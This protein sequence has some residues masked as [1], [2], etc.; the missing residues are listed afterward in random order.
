MKKA[1]S[2]YLW[3]TLK[4]LQKVWKNYCILQTS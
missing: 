2:L 4:N 3:K 1:D